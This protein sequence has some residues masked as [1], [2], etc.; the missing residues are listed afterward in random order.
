MNG[1]LVVVNGIPRISGVE[2]IRRAAER[3]SVKVEIVT[4]LPTD[5]PHVLRDAV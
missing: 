3:Q 2:N 1:L 5:A 4:W